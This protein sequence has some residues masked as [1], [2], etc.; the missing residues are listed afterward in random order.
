MLLVERL[1][2]LWNCVW[3][4]PVIGACH[5]MWLGSQPAGIRAYGCVQWQPATALLSV[6]CRVVA[7]LVARHR[8]GEGRMVMLSVSYAAPFLL[9]FVAST[10]DARRRANAGK[11]AAAGGAGAEGAKSGVKSGGAPPKCV[12]AV[13]AAA[14][15]PTLSV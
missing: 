1:D 5:G 13:A 4:L 10:C 12:P 6:T 15:P 7:S 11:S 8:T 3:S 2:A 14:D 9:M